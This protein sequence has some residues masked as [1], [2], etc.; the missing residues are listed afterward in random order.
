MPPSETD[1]P[2][3]SGIINYIA[4]EIICRQHYPKW[5]SQF[6]MIVSF[7]SAIFL[8]YTHSTLGKASLCTR[9]PSNAF[10]GSLQFHELFFD[11]GPTLGKAIH[12]LGYS[13]K[14]RSAASRVSRAILL[15]YT[16]STLSKAPLWLPRHLKEFQEPVYHTAWLDIVKS[17]PGSVCAS[18]RS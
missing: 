15:F 14:H 16:G 4:A 12:D 1:S 7:D 9:V 17:N 6:N 18:A 8:F 5:H 11:T 10:F 13:P 3:S 2:A